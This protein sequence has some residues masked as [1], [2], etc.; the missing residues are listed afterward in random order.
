MD[1]A[2]IPIEPGSTIEF[3]YRQRKNYASSYPEIALGVI[4]F[5]GLCAGLVTASVY[6][7]TCKKI[8]TLPLGLT[9][10]LLAANDTADLYENISC[11][12]Y[13]VSGFIL[14][15]IYIASYM[16]IRMYPL[17]SFWALIILTLGTFPSV[18]IRPFQD[19]FEFMKL[20]SVILAM[21]LQLVFRLD[22]M[23]RHQKVE[24]TGYYAP[25]NAD[26]FWAKNAKMVARFLHA[27]SLDYYVWRWILWAALFTNIMEAVVVGAIDGF[28][29][30]ALAGIFL[31]IIMPRAYFICTNRATERRVMFFAFLQPSFQHVVYV[32]NSPYYGYYDL[33]YETGWDWVFLYTTWNACFSFDDRRDHFISICVVLVAALYG[34]ACPKRPW[35]FFKIDPHMYIQGRCATLYTR[36]IILAYYDV[37]QEF[38]DASLYFQ[39]DVEFWWGIA[40][41]FVCAGIVAYGAFHYTGQSSRASLDVEGAVEI[42]HIM[43][44]PD[45]QELRETLSITG[46][47]VEVMP[48]A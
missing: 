35:D 25:E 32:D 29:A 19:P 7:Q 28:W 1:S 46:T 47:K 34:N 2:S 48:A 5:M 30:N 9:Q 33:V 40:N 44:G 38:M 14:F 15:W 27:Q 26:L 11:W 21:Q 13:G 39:Y 36:Y 22:N 8:T 16:I 20:Y 45:G 3:L 18:A 24:N 37:Y 23:F 43:D 17:Q 6:P 12:W 4:V 31:I 41:L 10:N 42:R